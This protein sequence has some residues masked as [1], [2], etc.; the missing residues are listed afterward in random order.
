MKKVIK[1]DLSMLNFKAEIPVFFASDDNYV[2]YMTV[3]IRSLIDNSSE[4]NKYRLIILH[5]G[6]SHETK[7]ELKD[8]ETKNVKISFENIT[9]KVKRFEKKMEITLRDYYSTSIYYRMFIPSLFKSYAKGVYLDGDIIV[10]DD[11]AKLYNEEIGDNL[12]I[13][14]QDGVVNDS[15]DLKN[16]AREAIGI[17]PEYYFNSGVLVMNLRELRKENIEEKFKY[18]LNKYNPETIAPDQDYLNILCRGKVKYL[19]N[20]WDK[21]P[22]YGPM[23]PENELHL[24]HY[25]MFR[26]PWHYEDVPYSDIFWRYAKKTQYYDF[27]QK[28]LEEYTDEQRKSDYEKAEI[29]V[30]N[31]NRIVREG[32]KFT[33]V[34][35]DAD[36]FEELEDTDDEAEVFEEETI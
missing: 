5:E 7:K 10:L 27:L 12:L 18:L 15:E 14:T 17:E 33:D 30:Q 23:I 28:Q 31:A 32:L 13:A 26:K 36:N 24:V 3:A 16:Y 6:M 35:G 2:P 11:I 8:L 22:D 20:D 34:I 4:E 25:N 21:M 1:G 29:L 9:H 19:Y